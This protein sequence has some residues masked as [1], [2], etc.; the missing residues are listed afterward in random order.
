M[1]SAKA[2][3]ERSRE[4]RGRLRWSSEEERY[5]GA[6]QAHYSD[7]RLLPYECLVFEG[8]GQAYEA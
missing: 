8:E 7:C 5:H 4:A 1:T 3:K 2:S 6:R